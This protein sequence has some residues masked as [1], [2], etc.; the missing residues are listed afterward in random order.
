LISRSSRV[1]VY[2]PATMQLL[3]EV[4]NG[5]AVPAEVGYAVTPSL[6]EW[7]VEGDDDELEYVAMTSAARAS[8]RLLAKRPNDLPRRVVLAVD[9]PDA[10]A[11][12]RPDIDRAAVHLQR[13]PPLSCVVSAHV[14][15]SA[16]EPDVRCAQAALAAAAEGDEDAEFVVDG[17]EDHELA[18]YAAQEISALVAVDA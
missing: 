11:L 12:P 7:Y 15:D 10:D 18:W 4:L 2:V 8:L 16:A 5:N 14:D 9:V 6:R 1:R 17:V 13:P 3:V